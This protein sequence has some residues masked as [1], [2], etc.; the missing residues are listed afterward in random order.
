VTVTF[1][2]AQNLA[3]YAVFL[4]FSDEGLRHRLCKW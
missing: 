2:V 3:N 4:K 1:R